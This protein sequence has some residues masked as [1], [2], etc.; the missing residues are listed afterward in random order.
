MLGLRFS[1]LVHASL[2]GGSLA[3]TGCVDRSYAFED[4]GGSGAESTEGA[5]ESATDPTG[6]TVGTVGTAGPTTEPPNPTDPTVDPTDPTG[7]PP[8]PD[9]PGPPQLIAADM[10]DN[11]T[12]ALTFSESIAPP[13]E[14]NPQ[15][16]RLSAAYAPKGEYY[17]YQYN[18]YYQ[19]VG[20]WN[21]QCQEYCYEY[22]YDEGCQEQCWDYCSPGPPLRVAAIAPLPDRPDILLLTFDNGIGSGVCTQLENF[23][24]QWTRGLFIHYTP[25]GTAP[26]TDTQG[27]LL[28]D[29]G[30]QWALQPDRQWLYNQGTFPFMEPVLPIPCFF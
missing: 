12:L 26:V 6:G 11:L 1:R 29:I 24:S 10:L 18:T 28:A 3:L 22:C 7:P 14:V 15:Q 13:A 27:E 25:D 9:L 19:E 23:P 20:N 16:F 5:T 4:E 8:P 2:A 30:E 17:Y 21:G